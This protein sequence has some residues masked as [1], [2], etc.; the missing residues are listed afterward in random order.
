MNYLIGT[1][2]NYD[3]IFCKSNFNEM[4]STR[5]ACMCRC[6]NCGSRCGCSCICT[7]GNCNCRISSDANIF[8]NS[9]DILANFFAF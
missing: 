8:S 9:K 1:Q 3:L 6:A 4:S 2:E 7:G 5:C